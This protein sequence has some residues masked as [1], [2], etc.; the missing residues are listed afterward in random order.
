MSL[1]NTWGEEAEQILKEII[2]GNLVGKC[3]S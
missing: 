2:K 3:R 1:Q